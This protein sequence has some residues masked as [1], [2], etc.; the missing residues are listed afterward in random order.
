MEAIQTIAKKTG[1]FS[2]DDFSQAFQRG[3]E[4]V[5]VNC[6]S[7]LLEVHREQISE[8]EKK[9]VGTLRT[10]CVTLNF[11]VSEPGCGQSMVN[12]LLDGVDWWVH[13][14]HQRQLHPDS[15]F[16]VLRNVAGN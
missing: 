1:S 13:S 5:G 6:V 3:S 9:V 15:S 11:F 8:S 14:H 16:P 4:L 7:V 2:R 10:D 12:H